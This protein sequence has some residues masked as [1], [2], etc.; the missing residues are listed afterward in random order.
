MVEREERAL[1]LF[2]ADNHYYEPRDVFTRYMEPA[3]RDLAIHVVEGPAGEERIL[4]GEKP[5]TFLEHD[6]D[7]M[8]RPGA[9]R[10][11]LRNLSSGGS[12]EG[13]GVREANRPEWIQRDARLAKMDEQGRIC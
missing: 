12:A 5:F 4:V 1:A 11:M 8:P 2:D 7:R 9:L 3:H 10:E 6:F 13:G